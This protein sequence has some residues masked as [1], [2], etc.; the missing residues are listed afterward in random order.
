MILEVYKLKKI[1]L[2]FSPEEKVA[3]VISDFSGKTGKIT[4]FNPVFEDL[5]NSLFN[6]SIMIKGESIPL[7]DGSHLD[8]FEWADPWTKEAFE[9]IL[10]FELPILNLGGYI[11]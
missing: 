7:P 4:V 10:K 1:G 11:S 9:Y 6:T 2:N 5:L 8:E 3:E